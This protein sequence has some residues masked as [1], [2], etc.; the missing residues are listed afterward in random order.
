MNTTPYKRTRFYFK[1]SPQGKYI[2]NCFLIAGLVAVLFSGLLILLSPDA[3][4]L[5]YGRNGL[6]L[7]STPS[8]LTNIILTINGILVLGLGAFI[9][10]AVTR[11][12]H[13]SA[14]PI[15]KIQKTLRSMTKGDISEKINLRKHD[16]HKDMA[17]TINQFTD[18][19]NDKIREIET[20]S[21]KLDLYLKEDDGTPIPPLSGHDKRTPNIHPLM[22]INDQLKASLSF[23]TTSP[24]SEV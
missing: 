4:S 18:V 2:L 16:E 11:Y 8:M 3:L 14:G 20:L 5:Q 10:Y 21:H 17:E 19:L 15:H 12:T 23:F 7:A 1:N 22:A 24:K 13:R 6:T 9:L